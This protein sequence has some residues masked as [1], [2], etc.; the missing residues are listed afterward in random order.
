MKRVMGQVMK[1]TMWPF[2]AIGIR[3]A[4]FQLAQNQSFILLT[5]EQL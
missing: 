2:K 1:T 3:K 5:Q 4:I